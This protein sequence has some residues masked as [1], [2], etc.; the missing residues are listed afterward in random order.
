MGYLMKGA[1]QRVGQVNKGLEGLGHWPWA[2]MGRGG[3]S[4]EEEMVSSRMQ[5]GAMGG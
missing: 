4:K 2:H 1:S 3:L 5:A